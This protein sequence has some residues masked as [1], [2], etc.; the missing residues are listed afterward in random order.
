MGIDKGILIEKY[1]ALHEIGK[2]IAATVTLMA[3]P[4]KDARFLAL[5]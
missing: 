1:K 3:L 2:L 5:D 4:N